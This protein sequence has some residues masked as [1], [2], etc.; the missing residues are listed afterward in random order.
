MS[1]SASGRRR[2]AGL[3]GPFRSVAQSSPLTGLAALDPIA[4]EDWASLQA[5]SWAGSHRE[6]AIL[7]RGM[8]GCVGVVITILLNRQRQ[9]N[10]RWQ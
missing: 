8:S 7:W 1:R 4:K 5:L 3:V 10:E 6:P 9:H 2:R